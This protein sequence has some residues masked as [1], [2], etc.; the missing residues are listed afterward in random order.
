MQYFSQNLW[1]VLLTIL[2]TG[3]YLFVLLTALLTL[4]LTICLIG[5]CLFALLT[6]LLTMLMTG[7]LHQ[8][9]TVYQYHN[10]M[11]G[12]VLHT[13]CTA[14]KRLFWSMHVPRLFKIVNLYKTVPWTVFYPDSF[15]YYTSV[16]FETV[17]MVLLGK[18]ITQVQL[19]GYNH[20]TTSKAGCT[21][22][23]HLFGLWH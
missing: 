16:L 4:L 15:K 13:E 14:Q 6:V 19:H 5:F 20:Q 1:T 21:Y 2:L 12:M 18:S 7:F 8:I 23:R 17:F 3:F 10:S 22:V 11:R 9:L